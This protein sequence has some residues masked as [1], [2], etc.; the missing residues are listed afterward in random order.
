M[1]GYTLK[2][3]SKFNCQVVIANDSIGKGRIA[4]KI[5]DRNVYL[6]S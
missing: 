3:F 1:K 6:F 5:W 4:S 2:R